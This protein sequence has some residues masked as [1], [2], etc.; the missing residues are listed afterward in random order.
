MERS[1]DNGKTKK[2]TGTILKGEITKAEYEA[3][4]KELLTTRY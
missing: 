3:K 1:F 4:V 2:I